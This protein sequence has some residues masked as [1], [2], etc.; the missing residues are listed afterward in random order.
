[1]LIIIATVWISSLII[2]LPPVT[3]WHGE[4][5]GNDG[6]GCELIVDPV[7]IVYSAIGSFYGPLAAMFVIYARIYHVAAERLRAKTERR[8]KYSTTSSEYRHNKPSNSFNNLTSNNNN[9]S[10]YNQTLQQK[11]SKTSSSLQ[12]SGMNLE[13]PSHSNSASISITSESSNTN[14]A[15]LSGATNYVTPQ[16][17]SLLAVASTTPNGA[18]G[19][20]ENNHPISA[21]PPSPFRGRIKKPLISVTVERKAANT[22]GIILGC[23]VLSWLPFFTLYI[24]SPFVDEIQNL[25]YLVTSLVTWMGYF[26]SMAN[27]IIYTIFNPDFRKA[28]SKIFKCLEQPQNQALV[29]IRLEKR[30]SP[31]IRNMEPKRS[32]SI[33]V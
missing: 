33:A 13:V 20:N 1:M 11:S 2:S 32:V 4:G 6:E 16:Q 25:P 24:I 31:P 17:K 15:T 9:A 7:Y 30:S 3:I 12:P 23:F 22:L 8:S 21:C 18:V 10:V 5:H 26:N 19:P 29:P 28:F 14:G 27:P